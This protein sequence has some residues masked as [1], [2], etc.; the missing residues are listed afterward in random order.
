MER[1]KEEKDSAR[2]LKWIHTAARKTFLGIHKLA[3]HTSLS[4]SFSLPLKNVVA[5]F[6]GAFSKFVCL[7]E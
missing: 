2:R 5:A 7:I 3:T 6:F 4:L 1:K